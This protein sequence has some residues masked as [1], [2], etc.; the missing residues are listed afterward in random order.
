MLAGLLAAAGTTVGLVGTGYAQ[1]AH[2]LS[3][4]HGRAGE[5]AAKDPAAMEARFDKMLAEMVP[6]ATAAQKARLKTIAGGVHGDLG[7][8][9]ARFEE[10][11]RRLHDLLLRPTIDRAALEALRAEQLRQIDSVSRHLVGA[12]ADAAE[13]LTP[14]QRARFA[15]AHKRR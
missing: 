7:S 2:P 4:M 15:A 14:E 8:V 1:G 6:D 12:L 3:A 5:G 9:H 10:S 11:H 13:V